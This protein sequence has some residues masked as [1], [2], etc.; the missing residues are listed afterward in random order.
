MKGEKKGAKKVKY[1]KKGGKGGDSSKRK[2][3]KN[4]LQLGKCPFYFSLL[5]SSW[6]LFRQK[7]FKKKKGLLS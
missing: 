2:G 6:R 4:D 5:F 1:G 7:L 3:G